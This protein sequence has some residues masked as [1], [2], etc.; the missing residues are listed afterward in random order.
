MLQERLKSLI[1]VYYY[2]Y[3]YPTVPVTVQTLIKKTVPASLLAD[4][5]SSYRAYPLTAECLQN[6]QQSDSV[7]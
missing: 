7:D 4:S 3:W 2:Y 5:D 1:K 6:K